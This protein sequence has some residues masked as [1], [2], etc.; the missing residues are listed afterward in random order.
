MFLSRH[1]LLGSV[2]CLLV[3]V[4]LSAMGYALNK[5]GMLISALVGGL[6]FLEKTAHVAQSR[7]F[8]G[9]LETASRVILLV[10][11]TTYLLAPGTPRGEPFAGL[12]S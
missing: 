11:S 10:L 9:W 2:V 3:A 1:W 6:L 5:F 8:F 12:R 7:G 4:G